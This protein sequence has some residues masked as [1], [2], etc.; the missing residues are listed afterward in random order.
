MRELNFTLIADGS[1]D[2]TLLQIIKW[3]LD[4]L[5][6]NLANSGKF[7]DYRP[8]RKPPKSISEKIKFAI[9][10]FPFDILFIHRD[11]ESITANIIKQ[12]TEEVSKEINEDEKNRIVCVVP[13][14]MMEAWLLI[15]TEA[16]KKA[17]GNRNYNKE[18]I[19]PPINE[20]EK[21]KQPKI[22]LQ[23]IL[24]EVS[25]LKGR[26]LQKFNVGKAIHL[27]AEN[28]EDFSILRELEA[29][30]HFERHLKLAVNFFLEST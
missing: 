17:A 24:K 20:L 22:K 16:I 11:A 27:V 28:I 8:F 5:Y 12:R 7:A 23:R 10:Y 3:S 30:K 26:N 2:A 9:N 25:G 1:S 19:L 6:P 15:N 4:D 21:E 14:K 13:I 18:I 29:Y